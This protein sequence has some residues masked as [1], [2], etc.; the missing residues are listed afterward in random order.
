MPPVAVLQKCPNRNHH[1]CFTHS[2]EK[3]LRQ[4]HSVEELVVW[5]VES[6][7]DCSFEEFA[8]EAKLATPTGVLV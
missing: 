3:D 8:R 1:R 4:A 5:I 2:L 6:E 7:K